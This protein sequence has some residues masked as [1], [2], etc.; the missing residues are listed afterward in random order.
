MKTS[1]LAFC[2][3]GVLGV[4]GL[5][6]CAGVPVERYQA[7][8]PVLDLAQYFN[9]TIDGW[10]MFQDRSGKVIKRF[11]VV[12]NAKWDGDRGVLDERFTWSDGLQG[13]NVERRVWSLQDM[14]GGRF[15]GRAGDVVGEAEGVVAGNALRWRYVLALP[16]D[17]KTINVD[18]DDWM[19]LIDDQ[20]ML[21]RSA[22]SKF[23]VHL[24]EVTLT[25]Q[26]KNK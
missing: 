2:A 17:G 20:V 26:R 24:G 14:G 9:G 15:L 7:Q 18:F 22:M 13:G 16:V 1:W 23:G 3:V 12:I 10:G 5:G 25:L 4:F 19:Y 6:G 21:N 11:H 8:Q